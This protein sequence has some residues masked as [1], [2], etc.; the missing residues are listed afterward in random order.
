MQKSHVAIIDRRR[1]M[2]SPVSGEAQV[3]LMAAT[4]DAA[5][6]PIQLHSVT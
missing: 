1:G 4:I 5:A 3:D 2:S 6:H